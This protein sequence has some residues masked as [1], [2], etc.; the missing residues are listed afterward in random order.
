[1]VQVS[2]IA[3]WRIKYIMGSIERITCYSPSAYSDVRGLRDLE[4]VEKEISLRR[5]SRLP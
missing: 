3:E 2:L 5:L 1:M 4:T